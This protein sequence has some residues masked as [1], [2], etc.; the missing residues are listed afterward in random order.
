MH[1]SVQAR[2]IAWLVVA[3][4]LLLLPKASAFHQ[5]TRVCVTRGGAGSL[6]RTLRTSRLQLQS[7][8]K[9]FI[10]D[11]SDADDDSDLRSSF[12]IITDKVL[13]NPAVVSLSTRFR[14]IF[15]S[16]S[17][18]NVKFYAQDNVSRWESDK[19]ALV[20]EVKTIN[21][22]EILL[23]LY[24]NMISHASPKVLNPLTLATIEA[25]ANA[26]CDSLIATVPPDAP[27]TNLVDTITQ[28]HLDYIEKFRLLIDDG[29]GD[30][31]SQSANQEFLCYQFASLV[32]LIYD[33]LSKSLGANFD[34]S[35]QTQGLRLSNWVLPVYARLQRRFVRFLSSN[36]DEKSEEI[37]NDSFNS[38]LERIKFDTISP[39]YSLR[40]IASRGAPGGVLTYTPYELSNF[41]I[42]VLRNTVSP[43]DLPQL[44]S[45]VVRKYKNDLSTRMRQLGKPL[46]RIAEEQKSA[47]DDKETAIVDE[48]LNVGHATVSAVLSLWQIRHNLVGVPDPVV[49]GKVIK[50][51]L[52]PLTLSTPE[53]ALNAIPNTMRASIEGAIGEI[54]EDS[55]PLS[56]LLASAAIFAHA[57]RQTASEEFRSLITYSSDD[58]D[59]PASRDAA[60][61]AVLSTALLEMMCTPKFNDLSLYEN[62]VAMAALE[63]AIGVREPRAAC[64]DAYSAALR[65][66]AERSMRGAVA[67]DISTRIRDVE[68][69]LRVVLRLPEGGGRRARLSAFKGAMDSLLAEQGGDQQ[70][71]AAFPAIADMLSIDRARAQAVV[72][73]IRLAKFDRAVG[74]ILMNADILAIASLGGGAGNEMEKVFFDEFA[75][76]TAD[77]SLSSDLALDRLKF[78]SAGIVQSLIEV[79]IEEQRR[80]NNDRIEVLLKKTFSLCKHP[81]LTSNKIDSL[82]LA[83]KLLSSKFNSQLLMEV[84][85]LVEGVISVSGFSADA[86]TSSALI[87]VSKA[88]T[89]R[90]VPVGPDGQNKDFVDFLRLVQSLLVKE[91]TAAAMTRR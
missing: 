60:Y 61:V 3:S 5:R 40:T 34:S 11:E 33:R 78:L 77:V 48:M 14:E 15:D 24:S 18:E 84:I 67:A 75:K 21:D 49:P 76:L 32:K 20:T 73:P 10:P 17:E 91:Y 83:I 53:S 82:T 57:V 35:V 87:D 85:R 26:I 64:A 41:I 7:S 47:L 52:K 22:Q 23:G 65:G 45:K 36:V 89:A 46:E 12:P 55:G 38:F 68:L 1:R 42:K 13:N 2:V 29:G 4:A 19:D 9:G 51:F 81:L 70:I 39:E 59:W 86:Q 63:E 28:V 74:A 90:Q 58:K 69:A 37:Y 8:M 27:V 25:V 72:Q 79:A 62:L 6:S 54:A 71:D 30:G 80:M 88:W 43:S 44:E 66:A 16:I 50:D 56:P 31:Y